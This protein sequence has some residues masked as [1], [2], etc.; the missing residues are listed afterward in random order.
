MG[1][2]ILVPA[3]GRDYKS[4]AAIAADLLDGKD[5]LAHSWQGAAVYMNLADFAAYPLPDFNV[6]YSN[7]RKVCVMPVDR[8]KLAR[9]AK[10]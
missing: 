6:R 5:F 4:K 10:R 9:I 7:Q 8:D 2:I 3:Y 1:R